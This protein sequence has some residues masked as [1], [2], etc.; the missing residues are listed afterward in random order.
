MKLKDITNIIEKWSPL[1]HAETFDNVGLLV[2]NPNNNIDKALI[3]IDATEDVID[4]AINQNC[5]LVITFH[6]II[7]S[8][9]KQI[10]EKTYVERVVEKAIK[11]DINIYAVHTNLDN[12]PKGVNYKIAER[13]SLKNTSLLLKKDNNEVGMG[14]IGDLND[15]LSEIEFFEFLKLKM[16]VKHIKHSP[17]LG[18][19]IKK[20]AV[21]GGWKFCY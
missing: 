7:F 5:N 2:G 17:L 8:G 14:M 21:L 9:I 6:P 13:L 20:I 4:E 1:E 10:T 15:E 18:K 3:T 16:N 11:N 19:K 12:N